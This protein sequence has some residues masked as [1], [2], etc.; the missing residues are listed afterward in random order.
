M[1]FRL[2]G[3]CAAACALVL[4]FISVVT[5]AATA[6]APTCGGFTVT[7][8]GTAGDDN[9]VGTAGND[10][11]N[12]DNGNDTIDGG[13]GNDVI[14]GGNGTDT[15]DGGDGDDTI[16]GGNGGDLLSGEAG[17]DTLT[18]GAGNDTLVGGP[19]NDNLTG[20]DGNDVITGGPGMDTLA[21]DGGSD[22]LRGEPGES[23]SGGS[24]SDACAGATCSDG[25]GG[26]IPT[27]GTLKVA[28][29]GIDTIDPAYA[30]SLP[31][32]QLLD[33]T[34]TRLLRNTPG[35]LEP[36]LASA[37]P[38]VSGG[39]TVY[40]FPIR[41]GWMFSDGQPLDAAAMAA[42]IQRALQVSPFAPVDG[43][44]IASVVPGSGTV[45]VTLTAPHGSL[46]ARLAMPIFC[47]VPSGT[48]LAKQTT[49]FP[50]SG[51]YRLD[52]FTTGP[53]GT[54][55]ASA[56]RNPG[57]VGLRP[58]NAN[59][60]QWV[61]LSPADGSTQAENG[62]VD[63]AGADPTQVSRLA[64]SYPTRFAVDPALVVQFLAA[65]TSRGFANQN[66]RRAVAYALDRTSITSSVLSPFQGSPTD[67]LVSP[68]A[69]GSRDDSV[70]PLTADT[71]TA[72]SLAAAGGV[73]PSTR[74]AVALYVPNNAASNALGAYVQGA[75][76]PLG[77]D[78]TVSSLSFGQFFTRIATA[79]EPWDLA[80]T[81]WS[82]DYDDPAGVL[83]PLL[84]SAN[85][86]PAGSA[87]N[88]PR[89]SD[90]SV[91]ASFDSVAALTGAAR[92]TAYADLDRDLS[93]R[94]VWIPLYTQNQRTLFSAR[95]NCRTFVPAISGVALNELC[96]S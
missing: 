73:T 63:L 78:V 89:F 58:S 23:V 96:L 21:G 76:A 61:F 50:S 38:T 64:S 47:A 30:T 15:I 55:I 67:E 32:W 42:S 95:T 17:G 44:D 34:C 1:G 86:P 49:P 16:I 56:V 48:P 74:M 9:I 12:G 39:G 59:A 7:I 11:I 45:T 8:S 93:A 83:P 26:D 60:I 94:A 87:S 69:A 4:V 70:F 43:A 2:A 84:D 75:L 88:Y 40:T 66:L 25:G 80:F 91:D 35:G 82:S 10:V 27:G 37:L 51:P 20:G 46:P 29:L 5:A 3:A 68:V 72:S 71:A 24:G 92:S 77:F 79:G 53:A 18:G 90:P 85:I 28:T 57:Y 22:T 41:A 33:A 14:C 62:T 81:G 65:N 13:A 6:A 36:D 52:T 54:T 19:G 31:S